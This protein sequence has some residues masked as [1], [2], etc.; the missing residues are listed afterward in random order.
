MQE[1]PYTIKNL[2]NNTT[3]FFQIVTNNSQ[4]K[5][6][7]K[8]IILK[9]SLPPPTTPTGLIAT[10]FA[11]RTELSWQTSTGLNTIQYTVKSSK[12]GIMGSYIDVPNCTNITNTKCN[13]TKSVDIDGTPTYFV[14]FASNGSFGGGNSKDSSPILVQNI[15]DIKLTTVVSNGKVILNWLGGLGATNFTVQ[16]GSKPNDFANSIPVSCS[17]PK[18][19]T[20][21]INGL[22]NETSTYYTVVAQN[23][24]GKSG[25]TL[26]S[27]EVKVTPHGDIF[28]ERQGTNNSVILNWD[29]SNFSSEKNYTIYSSSIKGALSGSKIKSCSLL[30]PPTITCTFSGLT[31]DIKYYFALEAETPDGVFQSE[32]VTATPIAAFDIKT[33]TPVNDTSVKVDWNSVVGAQDYALGYSQTSKPTLK[34][35]YKYLFSGLSSAG[36]SL[37][38][39]GL[40]PGQKYYFMVKAT[41]NDKGLAYANYEVLAYT[42]ITPILDLPLKLVGTPTIPSIKLN[43]KVNQANPSLLKY[44]IVRADGTGIFKTITKGNCGTLSGLLL[45][46]SLACNDT[47]TSLEP[48]NK[49]SYKVKVSVGNGAYTES[50]PETINTRIKPVFALPLVASVT[51]KGTLGH[52]ALSWKVDGADSSLLKYKI[53]RAEGTG[54]FKT[55]T[56]GNCGTLSGLLLGTSLACNDTDTSL[57]P[58]HKYRYKVAVSVDSGIHYEE[59][60]ENDILIPIDLE[61]QALNHVSVGGAT[62]IIDLKWL[63]NVKNKSL[64][65]YE[66]QRKESSF[67][68]FS[69]VKNGK[70]SAVKGSDLTCIDDDSGI[71]AGQSYDYRISALV[72]GEGPFYSKEITIPTPIKPNIPTA[73]INS[74]NIKVSWTLPSVNPNTGIIKLNVLRSVVNPPAPLKFIGVNATPLLGNVTDYINKISLVQGSKYLYKIE[75]TV[76]G[77]AIDTSDQSYEILYDVPHNTVSPKIIGTSDYNAPTGIYSSATN[78]TLNGDKGTWSDSSNCSY[79]WYANNLSVSSA[80]GNPQNYI[81]SSND[82]C[83][84]ISLCVTCVNGLGNNTSCTPNDSLKDNGISTKA[85]VSSYTSR[86]NLVSGNTLTLTGQNQIKNLL[87]EFIVHGYPLPDYMY[88]MLSSQNAGLINSIYDLYCDSHN[89]P[90]V[91]NS[92]NMDSKGTNLYDNNR[93]IVP[94]VFPANTS[95]SIISSVLNSTEIRYKGVFAYSG[96]SS[97]SKLNGVG[98][99]IN[100]DRVHVQPGFGN[101][102]YNYK[103]PANFYD[104]WGFSID[105]SRFNLVV[106]DNSDSDITNNYGSGDLILGGYTNHL[107]DNTLK[108]YMSFAAA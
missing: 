58:G 2:I 3:Y 92:R 55:I 38:A 91:L 87:D 13:D 97:S 76:G 61:L 94:S 80:S 11:S 86:V 105:G 30:S 43:W 32:E 62:P 85:L 21:T 66:I 79:Q 82:K 50:K 31:N 18:L 1:C 69:A 102:T 47:D 72:N 56:L 25:T 16:Q 77:T 26:K 37:T 14:V 60:L 46:T 70:C 104:F 67:K 103:L 40:I 44:E 41:N 48:G 59:S 35:D 27:T 106:N 49:Y 20:C 107:L 54:I 24:V 64:L 36:S 65:Q 99:S 89:I 7:T 57:K 33:V 28:K 71:S 12:S 39:N 15:S 52:V 68:T 98:Y 51:A 84:V 101:K 45:G 73:V 5:F 81:T 9:P 88:P 95:S 8:I 23:S 96:N 108:S 75:A 78:V 63:I 4:G 83:R 74:G 22:T 53:E 29:I 6:E 19:K 42:P 10:A 17:N 93:L 90:F 100:A 34:K